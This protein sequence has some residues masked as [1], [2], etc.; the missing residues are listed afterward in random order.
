MLSI[1]CNSMGHL[2]KGCSIADGQDRRNEQDLPVTPLSERQRA[3][4]VLGGESQLVPITVAEGKG[5]E[6]ETAKRA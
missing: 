1:S 2:E 4:V 5:L 3:V 6:T